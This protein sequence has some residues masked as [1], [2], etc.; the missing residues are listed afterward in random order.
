MLRA[1]VM[2]LRHIGFTDKAQK[3]EMALD[4]CGQ[5]EKKKVMTGRSDGATGDEMANYINETISDPNLEEKWKGYQ[6]V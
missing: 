2:L 1:T 6:K 3:L 4:I 5:F